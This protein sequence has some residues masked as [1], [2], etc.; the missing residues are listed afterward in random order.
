ML[1]FHCVKSVQMRSF[2]RSVFSCIRTEYEDL[3]RKSPYSVRIQEIRGRKSSIV[4]HFYRWK[5]AKF[6]RKHQKS[7]SG[8]YAFLWIFQNIFFKEP[9]GRLLHH[10]HSFCLLSNHDILPFQKWCHT[11]FLAD[12]FVGLICRLGTRVS[13]IFQTL[14]QKAIFNPV[15]Y[16]RWSVFGENS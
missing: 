14:N 6:I 9:F 1:Y 3:L 15:E 8:T 10:K 4:G 12:Y 11:H 16:L 2:F 5:F 7:G 13:S